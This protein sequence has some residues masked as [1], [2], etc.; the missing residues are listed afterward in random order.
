[1]KA[2]PT[3]YHYRQ[4]HLREQ[5]RI[6]W[7]ELRP[8]VLLLL[9]YA[10]LQTG[11]W[12]DDRHFLLHDSL[13]LYEEFSV[14]YAQ[15]AGSH[16]LPQ[17]LPYVSY[18]MPAYILYH[19]ALAPM[20]LPPM[21]LGAV[22]HFRDTWTMFRALWS[23]Q[24][25]IYAI[26]F[27]ALAREFASRRAATVA[28]AALLWMVVVE[29]NAIFTL[30]WF[31]FT[32]LTLLFLVRWSRS[33]D[34]IML[35]LAIDAAALGAWN[36]T[37][38]TVLFGYFYF[39]AAVAFSIARRTPI[40]WPRGCRFWIHAA[41]ATFLASTV[42]Y[43]DYLAKTGLSFSSP[44]RNT[45]DLQV[46]LQTFLTYGHGGSLK[47]LE[48]LIAVP[49]ENADTLFYMGSVGL[50]FLAY[51]LWRNSG[52]EA[53][54]LA[55]L[56]ATMLVFCWGRFSPIA[57]L[58][59]YLPGMGVF[60][61]TGLMFEF[62]RI[63]G[64]TIAA[65]GLDS[66]VSA[67]P[68]G[69][70]EA[71]IRAKT[72]VAQITRVCIFAAA[73]AL[74]CY[75]LSYFVFHSDDPYY[76]NF[77][78]VPTNGPSARLAAVSLALVALAGFPA[79]QLL[80][81]R[82]PARLLVPCLLGLLFVQAASY[83][84][85]YSY[86]IFN[87]PFELSREARIPSASSFEESRIRIPRGE[88]AESLAVLSNR[89]VVYAELS[90]FLN[91]DPCVPIGRVDYST[92]AVRELIERE[93]GADN[94]IAAVAGAFDTHPD[95]PIFAAVGCG[96][97]KVQLVNATE[98]VQVSADEVWPTTCASEALCLAEGGR[99]RRLVVALPQDVRPAATLSNEGIEVA[100]FS[101]NR[102][103]FDVTAQG[104]SWLVY[105]D[106]FDPRWAA[107][108]DG[109]S[110]PV[111]RANFAFKAVQVGKGHHIVTFAFDTRFVDEV[112]WAFGFLGTT[113]VLCELFVALGCAGVA[114][115]SEIGRQG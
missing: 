39:G 4:P 78:Q 42:I 83:Q 14:F 115:P 87:L 22:A 51:G 88:V 53:R 77:G 63:L 74:V 1:M 61:H 6:A 27:Y 30:T 3:A 82:T 56:F 108:V 100:S 7:L 52:R 60:R 31:T 57:A 58:A 90:A 18:G 69:T 113:V 67:S 81:N 40:I 62:S 79:N 12:F 33:G 34:W 112:V 54:A 89:Y 106:S 99:G 13:S 21:L 49:C 111:W 41:I 109:M 64:C 10:V 5:A 24:E 65:I 102:V 114:A 105:A 86:R 16:A 43:V 28:T 11:L 50:V 23:A 19:S 68:T 73:A 101:Y 32:P 70:I 104:P 47:M 80:I 91:L 37:Y 9:A 107:T 96:V 66:L 98:P 45:A 71:R 15:L 84:Y 2:G 29:L 20:Y 44:M 103:A 8:P 97:A 36:Q 17:W 110:T 95:N 26:G 72:E 94:S 35:L 85:L 92:P 46:D 93:L 76:W 48:A 25:S 55:V 59:Y 38:A 75:F